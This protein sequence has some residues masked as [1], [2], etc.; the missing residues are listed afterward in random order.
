MKPLKRVVIKEELVE[1]TGDFRPAIIL[2]QFIYWSE[3]MNDTDKYISEEKQRALKN[4][5]EINISDSKGWI[6]KTSEELID[7]LMVGMSVATI[8]KYIK[9]LVEAGYISQRTNPKYKWDKTLQY[10]VNLVKIQKDLAIL[11]Y[12]LEGYK[13][14]P[15][16]IIS[17]EYDIDNSEELDNKKADTGNVSANNKNKIDNNIIYQNK[18]KYAS[19]NKENYKKTKFHNFEETFDKYSEDEL[20]NIIEKSQKEKWDW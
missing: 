17:D 10:R 7:E 4:Q 1:L 8:R 5:E 11:G 3:R 19:K 6:Y 16:I 2:N 12:S 13:L 9:Q 14:L 15:N 20:D 18:E